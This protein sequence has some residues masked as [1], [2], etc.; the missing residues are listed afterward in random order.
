MLEEKRL[1]VSF[2][3]GKFHTE[4]VVS[5]RYKAPPYKAHVFKTPP[6]SRSE[7]TPTEAHVLKVPHKAHVLKTPFSPPHK[8]HGLKAWFSA[9]DSRFEWLTPSVDS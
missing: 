7:G 9:V 3:P 4:R 8:S 1:S 6:D 2:F 5:F